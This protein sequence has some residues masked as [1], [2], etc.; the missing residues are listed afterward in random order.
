MNYRSAIIAAVAVIITM[1]APFSVIDL[2]D[3]DDGSDVTME[4]C[5]NEPEMTGVYLWAWHISNMGEGGAEKLAK[6]YSA[7]GIT[8]IYVL[9]KATDGLIYYQQNNLSNAPK[10][11]EG[12]DDPLQDIIVAAHAE[13]IRV[14]AWITCVMDD[15]YVETH[16]DEG[17]YHF[18]R[19]YGCS[20]VSFQ[21]EDYR[22]YTVNIVKELCKNYD[23]DGLL[24]DHLR[25]SH[26]TYGWGECD[27]ELL[28]RSVDQGGYGLTADEYNGLVVNL[29]KTYGYTIALDDDGLYV[30]INHAPAESTPISYEADGTSMIDAY[31]N[32]DKAVRAFALM[33]CDQ[34][35][36][37]AQ[38]LYDLKRDDMDMSI[39]CMGETCEKDQAFGALQYGQ[40]LNNKYIFD[41]VAPMLYSASFGEDSEWVAEMLNNIDIGYDKYASLQGFSEDEATTDTCGLN[42]DINATMSTKA[43][44]YIIFRTGT[45]D[46]AKTDI[47]PN[48]GTMNITIC[49]NMLYWNHEKVI[50]TVQNG[51]TVTEVRGGE[52][53]ADSDISVS[54]DGKTITVTDPN[55][56]ELGDMGTLEIEYSGNYVKTM[57]PAFV[58]IIADG[59]SMIVWHNTDVAD[60][61]GNNTL[62]AAASVIFAIIV[63]LIVLMLVMFFKKHQ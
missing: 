63:V 9:V 20:D 25:Y 43:N 18:N 47:D 7:A 59:E 44:G 38:T 40:I 19:G 15:T 27:T 42:D 17:M 6:M 21:S 22:T 49:E 35:D 37:M 46:I 53:F 57:H 32:G 26:M 3:A 30:S 4:R 54:D 11:L 45:F 61:T 23:I 58:D 34:I 52:C 50:I 36:D 33:R 16:P 60:E 10:D 24:L 39:S 8:D 2:T 56:D 5:L 55:L 31:L 12:D 51:M 48:I 13:N 1:A 14:H 62:L 29:A 41:Y 28:M